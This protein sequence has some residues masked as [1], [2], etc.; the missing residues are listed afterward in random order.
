MKPQTPQYLRSRKAPRAGV[1][2]MLLVLFGLGDIPA[3]VHAETLDGHWEVSVPLYLSASTFYLSSGGTSDSFETVA[4]SA[5]LDFSSGL[6]PWS[7][8]VFINHH[9][10]SESGVDRMLNL[11]GSLKYRFGNWDATGFLVRNKLPDKPELWLYG[12]RLRYRLTRNQKLGVRAIS[13]FGHPDASIAMIVY[14]GTINSTLSVELA[15]GA[16]IHASR[17]RIARAE[18]VWQL[19]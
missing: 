13:S 3:D 4:A 14:D 6:S 9:F 11:G 2:S 10:S 5:S 1:M 17:K 18:L 19:H 7:G 12:S 8:S 16:N 15:V